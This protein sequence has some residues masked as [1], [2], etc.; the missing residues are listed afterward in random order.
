LLNTGKYG[1]FLN[2]E[3]KFDEYEFFWAGEKV[4]RFAGFSHK[5]KKERN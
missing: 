3:G 2:P 5:G 1:L 4:R